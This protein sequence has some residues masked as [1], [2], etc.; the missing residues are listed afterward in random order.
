M[1]A[2]GTSKQHQLR[3]HPAQ[4]TTE[5]ARPTQEMVDER[6]EYK[7]FIRRMHDNG[8]ASAL[9]HTS[10]TMLYLV[11]GGFAILT[12]NAGLWPLT[13]LIWAVQ[14]NVGHSKLIA[15]HESSHGTLNP[16][17]RVNE[18]QGIFVGIVAH[19]PLSVYRYVHGQHHAHICGE[20]DVEL[21]PF[22]NPETPRWA[23]RLA[24]FCE[25]V[26]GYVYTPFHFLHGVI[27]GKNIPPAQMRR[28]YL[29]YAL[30]FVSWTALLAVTAYMG[31]WKEL[32]IAVIVPGVISGWLQSIRKFTEHMGMLDCTVLGGTR[33]VVDNG[34]IGWMFSESML[35]ID[36]HGTHHRYA[37]MPYYNLPEATPVVYERAGGNL[38]LFPTYWS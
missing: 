36:Y 23:R 7:A 21:W 26:F 4:R 13:I 1:S 24:A 3:R 29:E 10:I 31:W 33:T 16:R 20:G 11:L 22:V 18:L 12:W 38:P 8:S 27:V 34:W 25:I 17:Y 2:A 28:I 5:S 37:K 32:V 15:F 19:V 14:G 6:A 35:H 9:L 30:Y